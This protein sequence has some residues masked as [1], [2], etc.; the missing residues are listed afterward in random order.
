M[1]RRV[2]HS[3]PAPIIDELVRNASA[4]DLQALGAG[5]VPLHLAEEIRAY[6]QHVRLAR[7]YEGPVPGRRAKLGQRPADHA[8]PAPLAGLAR[9]RGCACCSAVTGPTRTMPSARRAA[10]P[11]RPSPTR[12]P[13]TSFTRRASPGRWCVATRSSSARCMRPCPT[14][15]KAWASPAARPFSTCCN[16]ARYYP[17]RPCAMRWH[18]T[19]RPG[20]R[21]PMRLADGRVGYRLSSGDDQPG[22]HA[23]APA[24]HAEGPPAFRNA[25]AGRPSR[26]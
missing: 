9:R 15:C 12:Q 14:P 5:K 20:Y 4:I 16:R 24:E 22:Q 3:L 21:S 10:A 2:Y 11:G 8:N 19:A 23:P 17:A 6:Q 1:I 13:A 26:C 7:A 18:A 25:P